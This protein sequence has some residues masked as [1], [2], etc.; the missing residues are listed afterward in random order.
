M[1]NKH[2][3]IV[4]AHADG[5]FFSNF[6]KIVNHLA[7]SL[8]HSGVEAI[9]VNWSQEMSAYGDGDVWDRYFRHLE[10][11]SIPDLTHTTR[12][13]ADLSMTGPNAYAMM[14]GGEENWRTK[15]HVP[16]K[17]YI[18]LQNWFSKSLSE[19]YAKNMA[20][21]KWIGVHFRHP[22]HSF[23]CPTGT[24][25]IGDCILET[26]RLL[27]THSTASVYLAT[28]SQ[29][30]VDRF[31]QKFDEKLL[32]Y[33]SKNRTTASSQLQSHERVQART[34]AEEV[35][36]DCFM[37][38]R[39]SAVLHVVSNITTAVGYI[40]PTVPMIYY[41]GMSRPE[42]DSDIRLR[43]TGGTFEFLRKGKS[44]GFCNDTAALVWESCDGDMSIP[45]IKF[46]ISR[47]F[48]E[49]ADHV[50]RDI[51]QILSDFRNM[52]LLLFR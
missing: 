23:E 35:L 20:G 29:D 25:S 52:D 31:Q 8:G 15:Y 43:A 41:D 6:N 34:L 38:S 14:R 44:I 26:E 4:E 17:Q 13:Y 12:H 48:P 37:L 9:K 32:V 21:K 47:R 45:E 33:P 22:N 40:N 28:D 19:F 5:G 49:H 18:R 36:F 10:F 51:D 1:S 3:L 16:Y 24:P 30:A 2:T 27:S 7:H 11:D 39:C 50:G 46:W 42:R